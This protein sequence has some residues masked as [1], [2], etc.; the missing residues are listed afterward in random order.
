MYKEKYIKYLNKNGGGMFGSSDKITGYDPKTQTYELTYRDKRTKD[1]VKKYTGKIKF[2][3]SNDPIPHGEGKIIYKIFRNPLN[4]L[5][6]SWR[7]HPKANR[8]IT[9]FLKA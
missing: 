2:T 8:H 9:A 7:K 6:K 4:Y 3:E 5:L 1:L